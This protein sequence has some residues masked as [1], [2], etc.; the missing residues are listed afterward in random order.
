MSS[1]KREWPKQLLWAIIGAA[2]GAIFS[3]YPAYERGKT[4]GIAAGALEAEARITEEV[5]A[6]IKE[7]EI[8][9]KAD[10][11]CN[12]R[13]AEARRQCSEVE[14]SL[15]TQTAALKKEIEILRSKA[16]ES[17]LRDKL[18]Q[19]PQLGLKFATRARDLQEKYS[20]DEQQLLFKEAVSTLSGF[21]S[22]GNKD[23]PEVAQAFDSVLTA[24]LERA[25][26]FSER[27]DLTEEEAKS[28]NIELRAW[29]RSLESKVAN[30]E[31]ALNR[32]AYRPK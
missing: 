16:K 14:H 10:R 21:S 24:L 13:L 29:Y 30:A 1:S 20:P 8:E 32:I 18:R 25:R 19:L 5:K 9:L 17:V 28:W 3:G 15:Q 4:T 2:L 22:I 31:S 11:V 26:E 7:D 12:E 6:K 27:K 23:L